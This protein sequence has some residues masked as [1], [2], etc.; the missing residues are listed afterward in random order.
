MK[1]TETILEEGIELLRI[2]LI[3][4]GVRISSCV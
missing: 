3:R 2:M 4:V 1:D